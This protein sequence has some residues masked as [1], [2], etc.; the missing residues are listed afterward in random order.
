MSRKRSH[1]ALEAYRER[2]IE[3]AA[4]NGVSEETADLVYDKLVGF[5]GFGFP[6]SH[7]AAFGLLAYQSQWLRHHYPAEFLC[8]LLNEQPMG[9]YPP[10]TLVRDAQRR[11]VTVLPPD[12]NLSEARSVTEL[13]ED[14][15][16]PAVRVGL[17]Y[18]QTVS[19]DDAVA[20]VAERDTHGPFEDVPDLARRSGLAR[21]GLVAL[22]ESGACDRFG[23]RR[24]DLLWELGLVFRPRS[25][26][27]TRG[28]A[29]QLPLPIDATVETPALRDLTHWE[30]MLADYRQ[31]GLSVGTHPLTLL[32]P[33]LPAGTLSSA[34]L[35]QRPHRSV[36]A[37]AGLAVARQRP[38]TANGIVFMLL[39]DE[40][41]HVNLIVPSKVYEAHRAIVRGE[42]LLLVRGR[43][44]RVE[45]NR[46]IVV[47]TLDRWRP[48]AGSRRPT[49]PTGC[50]PRTIS[51]TGRW[52]RGRGRRG[53]LP[54]TRLSNNS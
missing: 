44:E 14:G 25:V 33:H 48:P 12:V 42:S 30:R 2:F 11:E 38:S 37:F 20:L 6:K 23:P 32:R 41:A 49:S 36:V 35:E 31:T 21:D 19:E 50:R 28:E 17:S 40:H 53:R 43:W 16:L 52:S 3:G 27:G 24:R 51:G 45:R 29:K 10:A 22:V 5:S 7:A 34:D 26:E 47:D 54:I 8:A 46:N 18:V 9:F 13:R 15:F 39:E 1:A 4:R